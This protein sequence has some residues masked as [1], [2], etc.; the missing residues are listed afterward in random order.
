MTNRYESGTQWH[1][2]LKYASNQ[3]PL[4]TIGSPLDDSWNL[5]TGTTIPL[6][7]QDAHHSLPPRF[8]PTLLSS[9]LGVGKSAFACYSRSIRN[10]TNTSGSGYLP[11][12]PKKWSVECMYIYIY[13]WCTYYMCVTSLYS[14]RASLLPAPAPNSSHLPSAPVAGTLPSQWTGTGGISVIRG[15]HSTSPD[16]NLPPSSP[17]WTSYPHI[18]DFASVHT[19]CCAAKEYTDVVIFRNLIPKE[20]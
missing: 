1:W 6:C 18:H 11:L 7:Q 10:H 8:L 16:L 3:S 13:I 4:A 15:N 2:N 17:S 19:W 9:R 5:E 14:F 12:M 20:D